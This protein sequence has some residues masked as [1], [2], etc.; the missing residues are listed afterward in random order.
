MFSSSNAKQLNPGDMLFLSILIQCISE[1]PGCL[2][3]YKLC[4]SSCSNTENKSSPHS[5]HIIR[6]FEEVFL[7]YLI[8]EGDSVVSG[9][10]PL[11]RVSTSTYCK[12]FQPLYMKHST[13][14]INWDLSKS[15]E[16]KSQSSWGLRTWKLL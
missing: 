15:K 2:H 5:V 1:N 11:K 9:N 7:V 12:M 13:I 6:L 16:K 4:L 14:Y 10:M 3:S 8:E